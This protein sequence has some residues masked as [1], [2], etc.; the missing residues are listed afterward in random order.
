VKRMATLRTL[1]ATALLVAA[2]SVLAGPVFLTGHDPDFH[3]QGSVGAQNLLNS[4]LN[5]VTN[6]TYNGG[7]QKFLWVESQIA[8]P[9]GHL[10]GENGLV[11]IGL[12]LGTNYDRAN[13]A[14]LATVNFSNYTAIVVASSFGGLLTRAELDELI[15]RKSDIQNFINAGGGLMALAD[16]SPAS[17]FCFDDLLGSSPDPF[18]FLP[19]AVSSVPTINSYTVTATGALLPSTLRM[20]T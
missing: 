15:A 18:G 5:F 9:S 2:S 10:I 7:V 19:V 6:G 8:P 11:A 14:A 12:T 13:A 3:A 20:P 16:C 17:S 4:G 1:A